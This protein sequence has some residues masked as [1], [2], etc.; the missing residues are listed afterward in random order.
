MENTTITSGAY[1]KQ[2]KM[3]HRIMVIA[4]VLFSLI[5]VVVL[6]MT[7]VDVVVEKSED[8]NLYAKFIIPIVAIGSLLAGSYIF[9]K[10]IDRINREVGLKL[11]ERLNQYRAASLI[12]WSSIESP[13]ILSTIIYL[14]TGKYFY[15]IVL[16]V[17]FVLFILYT[18]H[19]EK[20]KMHLNL[21]EADAAIMDE[22]YAEV[23]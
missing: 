21:N 22:Y 5:V 11:S 4:I 17:F 7:K 2:L 8:F 23:V 15:L 9:K 14:M 19:E 12:R 6:K 1:M 20:V 10:N 3:I 16:F 18:P 13:M